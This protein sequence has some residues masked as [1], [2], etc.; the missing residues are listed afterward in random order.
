MI[1]IERI[2]EKTHT[3]EET[4]QKLETYHAPDI[5]A[6]RIRCMQLIPDI[7]AGDPIFLGR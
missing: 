4:E 5:D 3:S 7:K 2:F 6:A 1:K